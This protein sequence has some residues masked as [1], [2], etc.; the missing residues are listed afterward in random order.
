[1]ARGALFGLAVVALAACEPNHEAAPPL[2]THS[3]GTVDPGPDHI[4]DPASVT[5]NGSAAGQPAAPGASPAQLEGEYFDTALQEVRNW[6]A[7]HKRDRDLA[8]GVTLRVQTRDDY[9]NTGS[10][11]ALSLSW[12]AEERSKINWAGIDEY[13]LLNLAHLRIDGR[14]GIRVATWW[15]NKSDYAPL[16]PKLCRTTLEPAI[17]DFMQRP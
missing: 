3:P 6:L 11:P 15:C 12:P 14:E 8:A 13:Q 7:S 2:A 17:A 1:M 5:L 4:I 16:T 9:G 10:A